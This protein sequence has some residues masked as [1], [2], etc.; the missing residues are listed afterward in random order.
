MSELVEDTVFCSL[1]L[2]GDKSYKKYEDYGTDYSANEIAYNAA[3]VDAEE[4]ENPAAQ[5]AAHNTEEQVNPKAVT[6]AAHNQTGKVAGQ[7]AQKNEPK[8]I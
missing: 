6:A 2:L 3:G 4:T 5:E 1:L 7:C 8:K